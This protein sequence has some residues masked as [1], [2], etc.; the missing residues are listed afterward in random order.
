MK[1]G[2]YFTL[3][4]ASLAVLVLLTS[5]AQAAEAGDFAAGARVEGRIGSRWDSCITLGPRRA[6]GGYTLRCDSIPNQESVFAA[7]DVRAMQGPDRGAVKPAP[8]A[9]RPA[10]AAP[11]TAPTAPV[12][13]G[14]PQVGV[15]ACMNQDALD[16]PALQ[17][18]LLDGATY[19]TYD[20]GRGGYTYTV[21]SGMLAFTS[22][23]FA[24]LK[25]SRETD[26][27]FRIIDADGARTAFLCPWTSKDPRKVH[28]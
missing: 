11:P 6:T 14:P 5:A 9:A 18:G 7:S 25:R 17:F 3:P 15:Y 27:T 8:P 12:K 10:P 21:A 20:G 4:G 13:A 28:W 1:S 19:S 16:V 26:K 22:G 2:R 24:G 23:P